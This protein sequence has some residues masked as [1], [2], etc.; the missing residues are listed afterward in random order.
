MIW[1]Y[2]ADS[3]LKLKASIHK[4]EEIGFRDYSSFFMSSNI[5]GQL[6]QKLFHGQVWAVSVSISL[7]IQVVNGL[8][9]IEVWHLH[10]ETVTLN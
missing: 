7:P 3:Q 8:E 9:S 4:L 1:A 6:T 2:Y 10:L 5:T